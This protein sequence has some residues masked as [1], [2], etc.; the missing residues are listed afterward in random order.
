MI[1]A[2]AAL[3]VSVNCWSQ[4]IPPLYP[5]QTE[6]DFVV[7]NFTFETGETL[8]EL[9]L[10]YIT[11]G[12]P[13]RDA[14]GHVRNAVLIMHGTGGSGRGF[15]AEGFGGELFRAGQPLDAAKYFIILPDGI[16]HGKSSKPSD[17]LHA[18]FPHYRYEDMV[19]ADYLLVHDGLK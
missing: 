7:R 17:G 13:D 6:S 5:A 4:T 3:F 11:I 1:R 9:R 14:S 2:L 15:M 19:R 10:H 18:R 12:N 8:P 16:G